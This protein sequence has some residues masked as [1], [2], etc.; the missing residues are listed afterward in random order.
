M[1]NFSTFLFFLLLLAFLSLGSAQNLPYVLPDGDLYGYVNTNLQ[2]LDDFLKSL[3]KP[4]SNNS[5]ITDKCREN[6]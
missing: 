6:P 4:L 3:G 1:N 2:N 5:R